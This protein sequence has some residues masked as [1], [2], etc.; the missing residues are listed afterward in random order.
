M[1][2]GI[3]SDLGSSGSPATGEGITLSDH[4][5][6]SPSETVFPFSS[7]SRTN[8]TERTVAFSSIDAKEFEDVFGLAEGLGPPVQTSASARRQ[9]VLPFHA[10]FRQRP[11][12]RFRFSQNSSDFLFA[13]LRP[14]FSLN[15]SLAHRAAGA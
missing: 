9:S 6:L 7:P 14:P 12:L 4:R 15:S 13:Q 5:H 3:Y 2:S 10:D 1:E 11:C 8:G